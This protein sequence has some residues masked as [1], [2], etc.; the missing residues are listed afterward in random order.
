MTSRAT[1]KPDA[2]EEGST[3]VVA[4]SSRLREKG[5]NSAPSFG[6]SE[7]TRDELEREGK[8]VCPF[9]GRL[10]TKEDL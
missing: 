2:V 1:T 8:A 7:G 6:I 4:P 10:L 3:E 9:T 5:R